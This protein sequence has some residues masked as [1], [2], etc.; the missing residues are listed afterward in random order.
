M[1]DW[2]P[3]ASETRHIAVRAPDWPKLTLED[4]GPQAKTG[5]AGVIPV[6]GDKGKE[7]LEASD[8]FVKTRG[9]PAHELEVY[10]DLEGED[11]S[12]EVLAQ[13]VDEDDNVIG[14]VNPA[15]DRVDARKSDL[16]TCKEVLEKFHETGWLQ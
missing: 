3:S 13:I 6:E 11:F 2:S 9:D 4:I 7:I 15:V 5:M 10:A 12:L 1:G 16:D 8:V 14:F